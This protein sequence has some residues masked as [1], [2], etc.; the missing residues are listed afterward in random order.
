MRKVM[1]MKTEEVK[2]AWFGAIRD[3]ADRTGKEL[4]EKA[5]LQ[6]P[7]SIK[8]DILLRQ[9][10]CDDLADYIQKSENI[11]A[12]KAE[13]LKKDVYSELME[14][15]IAGIWSETENMEIAMFMYACT[16]GVRLESL[17]SARLKEILPDGG[18]EK[19]AADLPAAMNREMKQF[20]DQRN[21]RWQP[22]E[23]RNEDDPPSWLDEF[24]YI[25]WM[26]TH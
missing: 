10:M 5:A 24:E 8:L 22:K 13:E 2:R 3:A 15:A 14:D 7:Q 21:K 26:I 25:D 19:E 16:K 12:E 9:Y 23:N 1:V 18:F 20:T 4:K 17:F 6:P 11:T